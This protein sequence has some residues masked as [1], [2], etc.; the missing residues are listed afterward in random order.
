[1]CAPAAKRRLDHRRAAAVYRDR[2]AGSGQGLD[3]RDHALRLVAF[4]DGGGAGAG[5]FPADV[6]Q[7]RARRKHRVSVFERS[8]GPVEELA[9]VGEAVGRYVENAH[10]LRLVEPQHALATANRLMD[11]AQVVPLGRSFCGK[12]IRQ[13]AKSS[14]NF[15]HRKSAA[16]DDPRAVADDQRE[17]ACID[18]PAPQTDGLA[19]LRLGAV[20]QRDRTNVDFQHFQSPPG[21]FAPAPA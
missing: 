19:F 16:R 13:G 21:P 4:P 3:D 7:R 2:G 8:L 11:A 15:G 18:Q 6:D 1:M 12:A 20:G 14:R 17:A 5:R 9:P 10:D